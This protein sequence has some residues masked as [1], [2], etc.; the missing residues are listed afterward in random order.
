MRL[1]RNA[2]GGVWTPDRRY[3]FETELDVMQEVE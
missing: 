3:G 1:M 2:E